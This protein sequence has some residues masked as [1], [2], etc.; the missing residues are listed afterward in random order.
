MLAGGALIA[1]GSVP[2]VVFDWSAVVSVLAGLPG[3]FGVDV[4]WAWLAPFIALMTG[5][6]VVAEHLAWRRVSGARQGRGRGP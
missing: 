6:L 3:V 1:V 4:A 2:A 5:G